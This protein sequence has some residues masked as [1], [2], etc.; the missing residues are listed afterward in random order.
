VE[1]LTPTKTAKETAQRVGAS[2]VEAPATQDSLAPNIGGGG[3]KRESRK[4]LDD[5]DTS[6]STGK[7]AVSR[8]G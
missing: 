7:L 1:G 5:C 3:E 8:S 2:N 4:P 6:G